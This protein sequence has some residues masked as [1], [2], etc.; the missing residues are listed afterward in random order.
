MGAVEFQHDAMAQAVATLPGG[1]GGLG[2]RSAAR[3]TQAAYWVSWVDAL[4]VLAS[5]A[6][7]V[8]G[9]ALDA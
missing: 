6:P 5:K 8:A 1:L 9:R 3:T 2:L 4:P 7:A